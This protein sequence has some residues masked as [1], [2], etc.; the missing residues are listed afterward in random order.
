MPIVSHSINPDT[1]V[2]EGEK[3]TITINAIA[4]GGEITKITNQ[5]EQLL[6]IWQKQHMR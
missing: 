1:Q 2:A 3:I 5:T 4:T 6:K